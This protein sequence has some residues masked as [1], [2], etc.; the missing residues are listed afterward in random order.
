MMGGEY[1]WQYRTTEVPEESSLTMSAITLRPAPHPLY[2]LQAL[3][4]DLDI[5]FI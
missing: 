5:Y 4:E 1:Y 2:I 3:S